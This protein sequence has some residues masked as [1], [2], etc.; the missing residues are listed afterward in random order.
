MAGHMI[1]DMKGLVRFSDSSGLSMIIHGEHV[2]R[3][4]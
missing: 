2:R 3:Y 4:G 1:S